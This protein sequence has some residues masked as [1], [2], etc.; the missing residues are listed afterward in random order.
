MILLLLTLMVILLLRFLSRRDEQRKNSMVNNVHIFLGRIMNY[1]F[2]RKFVNTFFEFLLLE[3]KPK[4][5]IFFATPLLMKRL[6][7]F[8]R[9]C[10]SYCITRHL[11]ILTL[12]TIKIIIMLFELQYELSMHLHFW[13]CPLLN[14]I[15]TYR[16]IESIEIDYDIKQ[17]K[18]H[19]HKW[20]KS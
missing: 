17:E 2:S 18:F 13:F 11:A 5:I 12:K 19:W 3:M 14:Y 20:H 9:R 8:K 15:L 7:R 4:K 1:D 6:I 10:F 16:G